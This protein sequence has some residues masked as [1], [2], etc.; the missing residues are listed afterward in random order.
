MSL[1]VLEGESPPRRQSSPR[2]GHH[3]RIWSRGGNTF[4]LITPAAEESVA[5]AARYVAAGSALARIIEVHS[6]DA[7]QPNAPDTPDV[8]PAVPRRVRRNPTCLGAKAEQGGDAGSDG[9]RRDCD[10]RSCML[11]PGA[12]QRRRRRRTRTGNLTGSPNTA[13]EDAAAD[14]KLAGKA[15]PLDFTLKDM[16]GVDV[17]LASFKGKPIVVEFLGNVV[18]SRAA[19]RSPRSSSSRRALHAKKGQDVVILRHLRGRPGRK[20]QTVR[21]RR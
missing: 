6:M 4:V 9:C 14:A 2:S 20:A 5:A 16:N 3:T 13:E 15:A 10:S 17:K 19:R 7:E 18:R 1:F 21:R 11:A 12:G 8:T